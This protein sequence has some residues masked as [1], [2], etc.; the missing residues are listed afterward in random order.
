M[1]VRDPEWVSAPAGELLASQVFL[2]LQEVDSQRGAAAI[3]GLL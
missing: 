1:G 3:Q 2:G